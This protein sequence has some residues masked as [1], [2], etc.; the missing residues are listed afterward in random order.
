MKASS[1]TALS[2]SQKSTVVSLGQYENAFGPI[3]STPERIAA[4]REERRKRLGLKR[5]ETQQTAKRGISTGYSIT[6]LSNFIRNPDKFIGQLKG[7]IPEDEDTFASKFGSIMHES[8]EA[9]GNKRIADQNDKVADS[10]KSKQAALDAGLARFDELVGQ[11]RKEHPELFVGAAD[12]TVETGRKRLIETMGLLKDYEVLGTEQRHKLGWDLPIGVRQATSATDVALRNKETG[13][14]MRLDYKS[15]GSHNPLQA[16]LYA[17]LNDR[18]EKGKYKDTFGKVVREV[19]LGGEG[20]NAD[21]SSKTTSTGFINFNVNDPNGGVKVDMQAYTAE[22]GKKALEYYNDVAKILNSVVESINNGESVDYG[23]VKSALVKRTAKFQGADDFA[24]EDENEEES[25]PPPTSQP[26]PQDAHTKRPNKG[27]SR[28]QRKNNKGGK[29]NPPPPPPPPGSGAA[30]NP[31]P[32]HVIIDEYNNI[33]EDYDGYIQRMKKESRKNLEGEKAKSSRFEH[34]DRELN[35]DIARVQTLKGKISDADYRELQTK[36]TTARLEYKKALNHAVSGDYIYASDYLDNQVLG[37]VNA[38]NRS[39][40]LDNVNKA[41]EQA[42][43]TRD[44]LKKQHAKEIAGEEEWKS[45]DDQA[46]WLKYKDKEE[47]M[48]KKRKQFYEEY[49]ASI[50]ETTTDLFA[51]QNGS[52]VPLRKMGQAIKNFKAAINQQYEDLEKLYNNNGITKEEYDKKKAEI[53]KLSSDEFGKTLGKE[54]DV[55]IKREIGRYEKLRNVAP[56]KGEVSAANF[57]QTLDK[58]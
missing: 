49:A 35:E 8:M 4:D 25:T 54:H 44:F 15:N 29:D 19:L 40:L 13:E 32:Q 38:G 58:Y 48:Q 17:A 12:Q 53:D 24:D 34:Y 47:E 5:D 55:E 56:L 11:A 52:D 42:D 46:A 36:H 16:I 45:A 14:I 3:T 50:D 20:L 39:A 18:E 27:S 6:D 51:K 43:A 2:F 28:K 10:D 22:Q 21:G 1:P 26:A 30:Q 57:E 23:S 7:E 9:W 41:V 33:M 31:Y 37:N